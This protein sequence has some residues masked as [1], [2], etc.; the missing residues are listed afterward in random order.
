M[1][2]SLFFRV[3]KTL[4]ISLLV[5]D[6]C[7]DSNTF[8]NVVKFTEWRYGIFLRIMGFRVSPACV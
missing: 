6:D 2:Q 5:H 4:I 1:F 7:P 8:A 3:L